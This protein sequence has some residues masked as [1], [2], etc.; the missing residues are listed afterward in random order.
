MAVRNENMPT[1]ASF[2]GASSTYSANDMALGIGHEQVF[3][4]SP[5][6]NVEEPW[7]N[8]R[9]RRVML[10]QELA[11]TAVLPPTSGEQTVTR[12][13]VQVFIADPNENV[14]LE[15][16]LLHE[17]DRKMTDLTDQELFFELD[18]KSMLEEHNKK[19]VTFIDKK[20]KDR[21][22][23]LEPAKVRDLKMVVVTVATL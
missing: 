5:K 6:W 16:C 1:M 11:K 4:T 7:D 10:A 9:L 21:T 15:H 2:V 19:R 20:V 18:M 12:R 23:N 8:R 22:E 14:P 3:G 17:G 13:I